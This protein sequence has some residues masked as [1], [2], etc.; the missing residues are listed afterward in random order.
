MRGIQMTIV[1]VLV[2][3]WLALWA[4]WRRF[5]PAVYREVYIPPWAIVPA[6]IF[7]GVAFLTYPLWSNASKQEIREARYA[8]LALTALAVFLLSPLAWYF[9][10]EYRLLL[11]LGCI[12]CA[13]W[14]VFFADGLVEESHWAFYPVGIFLY[15]LML[16][17]LAAQKAMTADPSRY[18]ELS[19]AACWLLLLAMV[20][21]E[22]YLAARGAREGAGEEHLARW[23]LD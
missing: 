18:W 7:Y 11:G 5:L 21:K 23:S 6:H 3:V 22:P 4:A 13:L 1:F 8:W 10:P 9:Y 19:V 20:Y 12:A 16:Y 2:A 15:M 17:T 14:W